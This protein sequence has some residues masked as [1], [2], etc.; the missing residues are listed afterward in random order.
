MSLAKWLAK[1]AEE[2]GALH[3]AKAFAQANKGPLMAAAAVPAAV[4]A[5]EVAQ[6]KID[7]F[8]T[9]QAIKSIGRNAK[10]ALV[11]TAEYAQEHPYMSS[12]L[13]GGAGMAG[14][15]MGEGNFADMFN[16]VSPMRMPQPQRRH[17]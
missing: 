5:Y 15:K 2:G 1:A 10:R 16:S 6:P 11:D 14:A 13:L 17:R 12:L 3:K 7:D 9:D 8:M 4:G